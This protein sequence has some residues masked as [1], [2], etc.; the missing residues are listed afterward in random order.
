[1]L[2]KKVPPGVPH[3]PEHPA[4]SSHVPGNPVLPA[5]GGWIMILLE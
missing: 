5:A 4:C 1:M 2:R 3:H